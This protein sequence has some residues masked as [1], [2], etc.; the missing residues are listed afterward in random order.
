MRMKRWAYVA[1]GTLAWFV[2]QAVAGAQI[3]LP[4]LGTFI[5]EDV[6]TALGMQTVALLTYPA[7]VVGTLAALPAV[8]F[9]IV[10]P[11]ESL[12]I[13][14]PISLA[15]GYLQWFVVIPRLFGRSGTTGPGRET[16]SGEGR[17]L[18][19]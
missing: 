7:G 6:L 18:P 17:V 10:T 11:I 9:G 16:P 2:P 19:T 15:A 14:G 1:L 12:L 3:T 4:A 13:S 5:P 8:F